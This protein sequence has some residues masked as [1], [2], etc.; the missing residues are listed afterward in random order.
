MRS[1]TCIFAKYANAAIKLGHVRG[2]VL[3]L[4]AKRGLGLAEYP[5]ALVKR[6]IAGRGGADKDQLAKMVCAI[7]GLDEDPGV[8]CD[9]RVG[10]RA[11]SL[12]L[13]DATKVTA[14]PSAAAIEGARSAMSSGPADESGPARTSSTL[15]SRR[16]TAR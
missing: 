16:A 4:V 2:V 13:G 7:L 15:A 6:T 10:D 5:P 9:R 3:L 12:E 14:S 11:H 8:E 1:R